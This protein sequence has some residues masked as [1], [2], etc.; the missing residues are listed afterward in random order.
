M[1]V[2]NEGKTRGTAKGAEPALTTSGV[3]S[4]AT[5]VLALLVAFGAD[6]T[7]EQRTAILGV[8]AVVA[9][10]IVGVVVRQQVVPLSKFEGDP[11]D[12]Q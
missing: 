2:D 6:L 5:A 9:P 12:R 11:L 10:V 1:G 3:T 4:A 8:V 7:P